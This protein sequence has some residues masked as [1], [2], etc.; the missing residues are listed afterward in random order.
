MNTSVIIPAAGIGKRFGGELPKQFV[1]I[2]DVPILIKTIEI[3]ETIE[4]VKNIV[5]SVHSHWLNYTKDLIKKYNCKKIKDVVIGGVER[6]DS[7][8]A[9]LH[10]DCIQ[11]SDVVLVHDAVRPFVSK[12]LIYNIMNTAEEYGAAIPAIPVTDTIK[13]VSHQGFV[14]KTLDRNKLSMIQ[15]PQGYWPSIL[16]DAYEKGI[17]ANFD[18]TDSASF[19][20]FCG[21]KVCVVPGEITNFKITTSSDISYANSLLK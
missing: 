3:F 5:I 19:V 15:T 17:E 7:V 6:S 2:G 11:E 14:V 9:G 18:G 13:E 20:E 12:D 8:R 21:Y 10:L 1:N 16:K 4:D